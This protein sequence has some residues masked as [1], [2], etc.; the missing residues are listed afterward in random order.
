VPIE[1]F[2]RIFARENDFVRVHIVPD[3]PASAPSLITHQP[4]SAILAERLEQY[5]S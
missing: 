5:Y 3:H 4:A 2:E 1:W